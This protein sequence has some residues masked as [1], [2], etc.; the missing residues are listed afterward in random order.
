[1]AGLRVF[2]S[3]FQYL[4]ITTGLLF[5]AL[6]IYASTVFAFRNQEGNYTLDPI[7]SASE[8]ET[9]MESLYLTLRIASGTVLLTLLILVPTV[10]YIHQGTDLWLVEP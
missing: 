1:M 3:I 2:R 10:S 8:N 9:L 5:F 6:P 7:R 4:V